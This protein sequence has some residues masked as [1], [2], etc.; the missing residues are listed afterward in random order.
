MTQIGYFLPEP[1]VEGRFVGGFLR[2]YLAL[3]HAYTDIS[4]YAY[5]GRCQYGRESPTSKEQLLMEKVQLH[6]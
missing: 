4:G 3:D 2:Q 1:L 5:R 6:V